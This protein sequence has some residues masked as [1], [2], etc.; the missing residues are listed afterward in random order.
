LRP[1]KSTR[2]AIET[3]QTTPDDFPHIVRNG[4][5]THVLVPIEEY[6]RLLLADM[7][8][9]AVAQIESDRDGDLIDADIFRLELAAER[10]VKARKAAG[11]TQTQLGRKLGIPQ[12]QL[13]R[14]ERNPDHT[15]VR[16]LK[17]IAKALRVNVQS[18]V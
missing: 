11:L 3:K 10:I 16:T 1:G 8:R 5:T 4:R 14:I 13:S 2:R 6:E 9:E 12:S 7:A 18:L 15:T 17:R